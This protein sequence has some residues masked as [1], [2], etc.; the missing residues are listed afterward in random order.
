MYS[1]RTNKKYSTVCHRTNFK[2]LICLK[3]VVLDMMTTTKKVSTFYENRE[4]MTELLNKIKLSAP[5]SNGEFN[6]NFNKTMTISSSLTTQVP[7]D[8]IEEKQ[9]NPN[10]DEEEIE[11]PEYEKVK[12]VGRGDLFNSKISTE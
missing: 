11:L 1:N 7:V 12:V 2:T 10:V 8:V 3:S 4:K 5:I 9:E 6:S